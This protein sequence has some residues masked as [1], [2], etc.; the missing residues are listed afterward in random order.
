MQGRSEWEVFY[1][2]PSISAPAFF[3][4]LAG[5][6]EAAARAPPSAAEA[7]DALLELSRSAQVPRH[8]ECL[9][10]HGQS[11][12]KAPPAQCCRCN[13]R[14]LISQASYTAACRRAAQ[15]LCC[16]HPFA[17]DIETSPSHCISG[18]LPQCVDQVL[19]L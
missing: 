5:A 8:Q 4:A 10:L 2:Y 19:I 18:D 7:Y 15:L 12:A 3:E 11:C 14:G 9:I 1:A 16:D 13:T 17:C 6:S